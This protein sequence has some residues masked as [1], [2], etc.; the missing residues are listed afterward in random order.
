MSRKSIG[1]L[2]GTIDGSASGWINEL[3]R[4]EDA[5]RTKSA[6][7]AGQIDSLGRRLEKDFTLASFGKN[8]LGGI[9]LGSAAG[10]TMTIAD[11]FLGMWREAD[12]Y[13]KG[14]EDRA[15][16]I[17]ELMRKASAGWR[18]MTRGDME[19]DRRLGSLYSELSGKYSSLSAEDEKRRAALVA[20]GWA[21]QQ[22][23]TGA[24]VHIRSYGGE[25]FAKN[26]NDPG[27]PVRKFTDMQ[28]DRAE[29]AQKAAAELRIEIPG[30]VKSI[31]GLVEEITK[32]A[33]DAAKVELD[34]TLAN[35]KL[36]GANM[37]SWKEITPEDTARASSGLRSYL[38][39]MRAERE[40]TGEKY[41]DRVEKEAGRIKVDE[42]TRRG[43]GTGADYAEI[44]K[45]NNSILAE[46]R[47]LIRRSLDGNQFPG[48]AVVAD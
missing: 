10:I 5:T 12:E 37:A 2:Y 7:I 44:T 1:S 16:S 6:S 30:L 35:A 17:G 43:L 36:K 26:P 3:K 32:G 27:M 29:S 33:D 48:I 39:D 25:V 40:K 41:F 24:G 34:R 15:A 14:L 11:H 46:I 20:F 18:D 47:D 8:L 22:D 13:A 21:Q 28:L 4:A 45:Q 38:E 42:M 19:P 23:A 31:K 9:G